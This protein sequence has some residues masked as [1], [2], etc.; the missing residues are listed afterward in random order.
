MEKRLHS[1]GKRGVYLTSQRYNKMNLVPSIHS[2]TT[3]EASVITPNV[4]IITL[5]RDKA[6]EVPALD[7]AV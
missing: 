2:G 6:I 5:I 7:T 4:M 3:L 1:G